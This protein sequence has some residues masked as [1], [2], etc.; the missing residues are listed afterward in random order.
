M[1][2]AR[3]DGENKNGLQH[4]DV[5]PISIRSTND[6]RHSSYYSVWH[7]AFH[8]FIHPSNRQTGKITQFPNSREKF[9]HMQ[10]RQSYKL[11]PCSWNWNTIKKN[12]SINIPTIENRK[13]KELFLW[14]LFSNAFSFHRIFF[15]YVFSF[16]SFYSISICFSGLWISI[17][18]HAYNFEK[19]QSATDKTD[20]NTPNSRIRA[21]SSTERKTKPHSTVYVLIRFGQNVARKRT[22]NQLKKSHINLVFRMIDNRQIHIKLWK[23][24]RKCEMFMRVTWILD[25]Y[26][27]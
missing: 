21:Y 7:V 4:D 24:I 13:L 1:K 8:S 5:A 10:L 26:S 27:V 9:K 23:N 15:D 3:N 17:C 25:T 16:R 22:A 2:W 11:I 12:Y 19:P 14:E 18:I 6:K 20:V